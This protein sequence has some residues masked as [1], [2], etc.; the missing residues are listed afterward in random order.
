MTDDLTADMPLIRI[1]GLHRVFGEGA[2]RAH[3]LRGIDLDIHAGEFVAIVGTSGSGKSTLMNILGLLDRPSAGSYHL[4]GKDVARLSR[5]ARAGLRNRLF[6]FV[7]QQYNLIPTLTALENVELPASHAGAAREARRARAAALLR[8]LGLGHRLTARPLQ[9][10]GGQQQRVSIARALMNGGAVILADEPTGALDAESGRQ[11]MRL[12]SDLAGRGHTVILITHDTDI[13]ARAGRVIR[14][15]EGRIAGDS[16][17]RAAGPAV[18][19]LPE[20]TGSR[21]AFLHAL[22]EAARSALAAIGASPVRTALTLSGI[23][24]G[25]ASVV[26]M[27]AIGRGAQ[28][29]FVK[30]ASAIG[31][32][33]VVVGSD[34][35]TR[36]PRRPLTL[37]DA[38]ALKGLPNVAGVMP[39]RWEQ[40]TVRAGAFSID[41]D[42]IGTDRDFRGVHGWDVV[43]GSF[44]SEADERG[45]SPVLLL[46]S[47]VAGTLFPD[48][49]D[50]TG[51]FVFV[52]MSPFLVGGV[53][54]SKGLSENG[55]DRDKVVAMPLR[56]LESRVY[57]PGELS[58]IVVALQDMARLDESNALL[59][60]AMIRRHGTE[61]FWLADAAGAFAAAEADRASQNLLLGAVATISIFVGGIGVMNIMFITVRERTREI[62]I[63]SATGAAM[64]DILV[65]F[66]TEATVLSALGGLAGLALAVGIGAVAALGLGMPV[67]FSVT[68]ALGALAGATAMGA[69][70]GL[71]P[72]IRAARLSPV[73][74]LASP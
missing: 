50:P 28:E 1:R 55:S 7:F 25:V 70:F 5:D 64:R 24:I 27:L 71:V 51:E 13:A 53:L 39:G 62:G 45:G 20:T 42:I 14:V 15:G 46:G 35:D 43:R 48:G 74:A 54:E 58:V 73:E 17:T 31:T 44:F 19:V 59:R 6:G 37:D 2:A 36:M 63:R 66:L 11:V 38:M 10:S 65:Q 56:S 3:V 41:T 22:R 8:S 16:G 49:R 57:G 4:A 61:D 69:A 23:V 12:L 47:T 60:E 26:A 68:V 67:V 9:M 30:R 33:W 34:Q 21:S 29:E 72:A 40:A 52:N 18:P 32:N